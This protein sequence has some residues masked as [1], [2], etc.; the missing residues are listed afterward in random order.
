VVAVQTPQV[1]EAGLLRRAYAQKNLESTDDA[2]L[3]ERLG[4][5]VVVV[6]GE[7]TN[8]KITRPSDMKIA[9]AV[10]GLKPAAERETHKRF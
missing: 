6:E 1:F 2:Q 9:M 7:V 5:R 4:E 10:L 3:V 8:I